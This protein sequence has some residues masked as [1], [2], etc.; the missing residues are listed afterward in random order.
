MFFLAAELAPNPL[1]ELV[2]LLLEVPL[3]TL[4]PPLCLGLVMR[5]FHDLRIGVYHNIWLCL[6]AWVCH[7]WPRYL[8]GE[9]SYETSEI[10]RNQ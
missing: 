6:Y 10:S 7:P 2:Y 4:D 9:P 5:H 8:A 3:L 1:P